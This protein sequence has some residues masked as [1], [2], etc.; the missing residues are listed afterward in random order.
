MCERKRVVGVILMFK[1]HEQK[2][3]NELEDLVELV[4]E[5]GAEMRTKQNVGS[6][7]SHR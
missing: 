1:V 4:K 5:S 2:G 6:E 7:R 3:G